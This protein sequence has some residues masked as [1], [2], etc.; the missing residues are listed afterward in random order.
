VSPFGARGANSVLQDTDNLCWKLRLVLAGQAPERLLDTYSDERTYAADEN[1]L[2]STRSTDFITPKSEVSRGFRDAVLSLAASCPFARTLVNSGRLS[3]PAFL[4]ESRLNTPDSASFAGG[5]VPGAPADDAP[6]REGDRGGWLLDAIG[7]RFVALVYVQDP[8]AFLARHGAEVQVLA[9]AP[10]A[11]EVL[12]VAPPDAAVRPDM[13][14]LVDCAGRY[15]ERYDARDGTTY[16]LRP[17]QHVAARWRAFDADALRH[18]IAR[19][20]CNEH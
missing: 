6:L 10:I 5:M 19:A 13:R 11:V 3:V 1:I 8:A 15:A 7:G 14:T 18:A 17:D 2:N 20:T 16:L 4:L 9:A 12:A